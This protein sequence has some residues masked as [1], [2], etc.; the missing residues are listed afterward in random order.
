MAAAKIVSFFRSSKPGALALTGPTGCGK[1]HVI[2]DAARQAGVAVTHHDLAQGTIEWGRLGRQQL[3][4][5][6][7]AGCVL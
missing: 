3:T 1:H 6:G 2:A 7:L 5:A 4:S